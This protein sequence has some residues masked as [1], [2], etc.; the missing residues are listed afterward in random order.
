MTTAISMSHQTAP[1][2]TR[3]RFALAPDARAALLER[4]AEVGGG[5]A[6]L[7]T[8]NR[9]ELYVS[10]EIPPRALVELVASATTGSP[11]LT[12]RAFRP[13][14]GSDAVEH[15]FRVAAGLDSLVLGEAEILGQVRTAFS[16]AVAAGTTDRTITHL[17]HSA[18]RTGRRARAETAIG[19]HSVSVS[20]LAARAADQHFDGIRER[21]AIVVGAGDAGRLAASALRDRGIG[22][23]IIANRTF[24]TA[25]VLAESLRAEVVPLDALPSVLPAADIVLTSIGAGIPVISVKGAEAAMAQRE[26]ATMLL[27]DIAVPRDIDPAAGEVPGVTLLDVDHL[28]GL[29]AENAALRKAEVSAVEGIVAASVA[30]FATWAEQRAAIP[31]IRDLTGWADTVRARQVARALKGSGLSPEERER[32]LPLLESFSRSLVQQILHPPIS[33]AREGPGPRNLAALRELFDL[34]SSEG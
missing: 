19:A 26:G 15:L 17:F 25:R 22:R 21:T 3:E 7:G 14:Q 31:T 11:E 30:D 6:L 33:A 10:A 4:A 13:Y 28:E 9:L 32:I 8:C 18:I 2:G 34:D 16:E 29:A 12:R 20:A 1:V 23:L 27:I 5:A 24:E